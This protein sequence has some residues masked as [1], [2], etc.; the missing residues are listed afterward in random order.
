[1]STSALLGLGV[2]SISLALAPL[3]APSATPAA[4]M[5]HAT[6]LVSAAQATAAASAAQAPGARKPELV[7]LVNHTT[8]RCLDL[9]GAGKGTRFGPVQQWLCRPEIDDNQRFVTLPR[10]MHGPYERFMLQN[11]KDRYCLDLPT[12]GAVKSGTRLREGLCR[13]ND[14]QMWYRIPVRGGAWLLVNEKSRLCLDVVGTK[15][16][17]LNAPLAVSTCSMADDHVW[18]M[19]HPSKVTGQDVPAPKPVRRP[20]RT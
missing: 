3:A 2:A 11:H 19:L 6:S 13:A 5:T 8:G 1:M 17:A 12:A 14:N 20:A 9:P 18:R 4:S 7:I 16:T 15:S 10:G